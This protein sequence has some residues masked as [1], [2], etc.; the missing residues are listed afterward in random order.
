[1]WLDR[2]D[3][4]GAEGRTRR[5]RTRP[6]MWPCER[7]RNMAEGFTAN[8]A[9]LGADHVGAHPTASFFALWIDTLHCGARH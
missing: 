8:R 3:L 4:A 9:K 2:A 7:R 5:V 6:K 1:M